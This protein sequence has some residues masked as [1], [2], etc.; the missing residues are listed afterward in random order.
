[1]VREY[2]VREYISLS[3]NADLAVVLAITGTP[4]TNRYLPTNAGVVLQ[5]FNT[6]I[7]R[8]SVAAGLGFFARDRKDP[9]SP[10]A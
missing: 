5:L 9:S 8:G 10:T 6:T 3:G 7:V 1:M 2:V 4:G